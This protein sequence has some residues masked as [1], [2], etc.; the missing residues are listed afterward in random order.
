MDEATASV[1]Q[2]TDL[3]IQQKIKELF[4]KRFS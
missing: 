4:G 1:D 2:A 3:L